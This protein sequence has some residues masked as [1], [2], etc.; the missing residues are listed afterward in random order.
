MKIKKGEILGKNGQKR[1]K[2]QKEDQANIGIGLVRLVGLEENKKNSDGK[3]LKTNPTNKNESNYQNTPQKLDLT[4]PT[5]PTNEHKYDIN[6]KPTKPTKPT[7]ITNLTNLTST[8]L[9]IPENKQDKIFYYLFDNGEQPIQKLLDISGMKSKDSFYTLKGRMQNKLIIT[10]KEGTI[11]FFNISKE[12]REQLQFKINQTLENKERIKQNKIEAEKRQTEESI[13]Q[14][15][16]LIKIKKI[17]ENKNIVSYQNNNPFINLK[18]LKEQES[19]IYEKLLIHTEE[20]QQLFDIAFEEAG[21]NDPYT[22]FSNLDAIK[23][24]NIENYRTKHLGTALCSE[25]K[26]TTMSKVSSIVTNAKFECPSCGTIMS[27]IQI[28]KKF[29]EPSRCSCGRRGGFKEIGKDMIDASI[30]IAEDIEPK[31]QLPIS[32][33]ITCFAKGDLLK[34]NEIEKLIPG[35]HL[36]IFG[37]L[38]EIAISGHNGAMLTC[39]DWALEIISIEEF[40]PELNSIDFTEEDIEEFEELSSRINSEG[41]D[42]FTE[43]YAPDVEG[44]KTEKKALIIQ[45]SQRKNKSIS[46]SKT[47]SHIA[48]FGDPGVSKSVLSKFAIKVTQGSSYSSGSG[49]S[50]VGLTASVVKEDGIGWVMKPGQ[51]PL[52]RELAILDE[53]NLISDEDKPK[54]QEAMSESKISINKAGIQASPPVSCG[55]LAIANPI[56]GT[57]DNSQTITKQLNLLPQQLNRFDAIFIKI[58]SKDINKD[59]KIAKIMLNRYSNT[60]EAEYNISFLRKF[61]TYTRNLNEPILTEESKKY[62]IKIYKK[63][64]QETKNQSSVLINPR[65]LESITRLSVGHTKLRGSNKVLKKDIDEAYNILSKTYLNLSEFKSNEEIE[66]RI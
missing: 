56:R 39:F 45:G 32:K 6:H 22:K 4:K 23:T 42:F 61:F 51:L 13:N 27:V 16:F 30:L 62:I 24:L 52:T 60:I 1:A 2:T 3:D 44:Y 59:E 29:K 43:S 55:I 64:R 53:Y 28:D 35:N 17:I 8:L 57:F 37:V 65:F 15:E 21:F 58:D 47:K 36:R 18:E 10:K 12:F 14:E 66:K 9:G 7:N 63:V 19:F 49:S 5:N 20:T 41:L 48:I 38:K 50:G 11:S 31:S 54:L 33:N 40:D 46:D 26:I 34:P 25:A